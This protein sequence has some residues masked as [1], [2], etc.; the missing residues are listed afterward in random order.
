MVLYLDH[1]K[2]VVPLGTE[3][4][5][6]R[7]VA[8]RTTWVGEATAPLREGLPRVAPVRPG[9]L[10]PGTFIAWRLVMTNWPAPGRRFDYL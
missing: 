1:R 5:G 9:A 10:A 2:G 3:A 4:R 8:K 6:P 7:S